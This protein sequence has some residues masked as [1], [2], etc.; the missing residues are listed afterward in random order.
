MPCNH[1]KQVVNAAGE[2]VAADMA[3]EKAPRSR[4]KIVVDWAG[5]NYPIMKSL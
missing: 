5:V 4:N 1:V 2:S 3:L